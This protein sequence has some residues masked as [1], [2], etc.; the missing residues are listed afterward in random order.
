MKF[1]GFDD[2]GFLG[3]WVMM[4]MMMI[5]FTTLNTIVVSFV[6]NLKSISGVNGPTQ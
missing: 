5:N 1:D 2:R 6:F 3:Y 4:M